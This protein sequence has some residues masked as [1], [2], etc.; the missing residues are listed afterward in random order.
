MN[1]FFGG[2]VHAGMVEV[3][4][5]SLFFFR[6]KNWQSRNT[7]VRIN[8]NRLQQS[9]KMAEKTL[10]RC[11]IKQV[12]CVLDGARQSFGD[13]DEKQGEVR[14]RPAAVDGKGAWIHT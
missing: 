10:N 11:G 7:A 8:S 9:P 4:Q 5:Q 2:E 3:H 1:A 12:R 6:C 14:L 13:F